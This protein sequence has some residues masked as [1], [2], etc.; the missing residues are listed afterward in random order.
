[1]AFL[2]EN[3]VLS[4][5]KS[6]NLKYCYLF[7]GEDSFLKRHYVKKLSSAVVSEDDFFN[8]QKFEGDCDLQEVYEAVSQYPMM[9][10]KKCVILKDY[11]FEKCDSENF[12]RLLSLCTEENDTCVFIVWFDYTEFD[13]K[14]SERFKKLTTAI[15][16]KN[17]SV[18]QFSYKTEA[19][20][21]KILIDGAKKRGCT[22][23]RDAA[24]CLIET[25]GS[26]IETLQNELTKVCAY[27][28]GE[29]TVAAV[30]E[31]CI[32]TI[33][34]SVFNLSS[35]IF[36]GDVGKALKVLDELTFMNVTAMNVFYTVSAVYVDL[37]R[38]MALKQTGVSYNTALADFAYKN[39]YFLLE[40]AVKQAR[41]LTFKQVSL[42]LCELVTADKKMKSYR[43]DE[44]R[45]LEELIVRL[46]YIAVKGESVDKT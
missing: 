34:Q 15:Q 38:A 40:R 26:D 43:S 19:E 11:P 5:I 31:V 35:H 45:I 2:G 46:S 39:K 44:K 3:A 27:C 20:L 30:K 24:L 41:K 32:K 16:K 10:D 4:D 8:Y 36:S 28:G 12:A 18:L 29:V 33:E 13:S 14:K 22:L 1:M 37:A 42:S 23:N 6:E 17:Y 7:F 25:V 9:N 21:V